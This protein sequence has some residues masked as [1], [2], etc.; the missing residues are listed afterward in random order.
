MRHK[1]NH[2]LP[3]NRRYVDDDSSITVRCELCGDRFDVDLDWVARLIAARR[4]RVTQ[5]RARRYYSTSQLNEMERRVD[6]EEQALLA[7]VEQE[8]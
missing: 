7:Y 8:N 1:A 2:P 6:D 5:E 3:I 4:R